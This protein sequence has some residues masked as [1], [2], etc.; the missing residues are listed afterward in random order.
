MNVLQ[1]IIIRPMSCDQV[2]TVVD[3]LH[4][5]ADALLAVRPDDEKP[6][7]T[8]EETERMLEQAAEDGT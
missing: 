7:P 6:W 2:D 3:L 1:P 4:Q 8:W 5:L